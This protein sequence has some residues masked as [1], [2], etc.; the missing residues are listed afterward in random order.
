MP[1]F[2]ASGG[3]DVLLANGDAGVAMAG[4]LLGTA[5]FSS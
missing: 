4:I 3:G 5:K 2:Q 1:I